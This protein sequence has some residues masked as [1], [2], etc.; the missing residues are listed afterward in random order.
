MAI[1]ATGGAGFSGSNFV[2]D[3]LAQLDEPLVNLGERTCAG[4]RETLAS[5]Q[6]DA[7]HVFVQRGRGARGLP[8]PAKAA[9]RLRVSTDEVYGSSH[10]TQIT[11]A[12]DRP[13]HGQRHT[14]DAREIERE[15]SRRPAETFEAGTRKTVQ[16]HLGHRERAQRVQ[17]GANRER[18]SQHY[19]EEVAA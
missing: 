16:W 7:C 13:A 1:L 2:L 18:V 8:E 17:G 15:L 11:P 19:G 14:I 4:K 6:G 10:K 9:F 5:Q 12:T 3:W